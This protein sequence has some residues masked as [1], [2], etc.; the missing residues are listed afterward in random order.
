MTTNIATCRLL[1]LVTLSFSLVLRCMIILL[2]KTS[3]SGCST[4]SRLYLWLIW[5]LLLLWSRLLSHAILTIFKGAD[6]RMGPS[7]T[8]TATGEC[9]SGNERTSFCGLQTAVGSCIVICRV[10]NNDSSSSGFST[11]ELAEF[12][13]N[14]AVMDEVELLFAVSTYVG[15]RSLIWWHT[16]HI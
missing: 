3:D 7:T 2:S 13:V 8:T 15:W 16:L 10:W 12:F 11:T 1:I 9:T 5:L 4:P 14:E 6:V